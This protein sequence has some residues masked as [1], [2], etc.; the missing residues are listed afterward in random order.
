MGAGKGSRKRD[1][2][3]RKAALSLPIYIKHILYIICMS[4][5]SKNLIPRAKFYQL[6]GFLTED[7]MA[8][9]R[10]EHI[11]QKGGGGKGDYVVL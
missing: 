2:Q 8:G 6:E 10:E 3:H 1:E 11:T 9:W 7:K 4:L 5:D